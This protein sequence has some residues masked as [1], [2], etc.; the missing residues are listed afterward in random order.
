VIL[1]LAADLDSL[2]G[3]KTFLKTQVIATVLC[4]PHIS[5]QLAFLVCFYKC[6][7][8]SNISLSYFDILF[9]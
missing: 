6:L 3:L 8:G 4:I 7:S 9:M 1:N 5:A 2:T